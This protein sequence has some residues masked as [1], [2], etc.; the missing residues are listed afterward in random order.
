M[1]KYCTAGS[2]KSSFVGNNLAFYYNL[3]PRK[4]IL[5][6]HLNLLLIGSGKSRFD[7]FVIYL[8]GNSIPDAQYMSYLFCKLQ[9]ISNTKKLIKPKLTK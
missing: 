6:A 1:L 9:Y 4:Q 3:T 2:Q 7:P 8:M 5:E